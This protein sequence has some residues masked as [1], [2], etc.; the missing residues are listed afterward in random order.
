MG[1]KASILGLLSVLGISFAQILFKITA[2][3]M[4]RTESN[5]IEWRR[6]FSLHLIA[7]LA[8]YGIASL[9]WIWLLRL[10]PLQKAYPLMALAYII[11]PILGRVF[12]KEE[13]RF[14]SIVGGIVILVGVCVSVW[15]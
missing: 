8:I 10:I 4:V 3:R 5:R 11:V 6:M 15:G 7:N 14:R 1:L 9:L 12:L 13:L 2:Q